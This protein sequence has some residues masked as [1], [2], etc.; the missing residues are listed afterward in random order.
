MSDDQ[1]SLCIPG[2]PELPYQSSKASIRRVMASKC[3][4]V[5]SYASAMNPILR[6]SPHPCKIAVL[7]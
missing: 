6:P 5:V 7:K 3:A 2:T 1:A 4:V